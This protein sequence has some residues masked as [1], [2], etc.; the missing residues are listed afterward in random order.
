[1]TENFCSLHSV[2]LILSYFS[3]KR[4]IIQFTCAKLVL[5]TH[6]SVGGAVRNKNVCQTFQVLCISVLGC[7][8]KGQDVYWGIVD[9]MANTL[10]CCSC[11]SKPLHGA[12]MFTHHQ[13]VHALS[14][15]TRFLFFFFFCEFN[16]S[17][18]FRVELHRKAMTRLVHAYYVTP[19]QGVLQKVPLWDLV[20]K[21]ISVK[22]TRNIKTSD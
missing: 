15:V 3:K 20:S 7:V 1:M 17:D 21:T 12:V 4:Q 19:P 2:W 16:N 13:N 18:F 22:D 5:I 9:K 14:T 11:H 8:Y 10:I 6:L